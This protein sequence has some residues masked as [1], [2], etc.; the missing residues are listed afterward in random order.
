M[1]VI[2]NEIQRLFPVS[3]GDYRLELNK[4]IYDEEEAK[5]RAVDYSLQKK[6][7]LADQSLTIPV[8]GIFDLYKNNKKVQTSKVLLLNL[9]IKTPRE[10]FIYKGTEYQIMNQLRLKP[11]IYAR[12]KEN[13][14]PEVQF[15]LAKWGFRLF[16]AD[17]VLF[18]KF[19]KGPRIPV[20]TVAKVLGISDEELR[21][22][23]P[24]DELFEKNRI[25][26]Y[27]ALE[28]WYETYYDDRGIENAKSALKS[29]LT[30]GYR[31]DPQVLKT[32]LGIE[33]TVLTKE[34][35]LESIKKFYKL[36]AGEIFPDDRDALYFKDFFSSE[37]ILKEHFSDETVQNNILRKIRRALLSGKSIPELG[38]NYLL[39]REIDKIFDM[40][41]TASLKQTNPVAILDNINRATIFG[42]GGIKSEYAVTQWARSVNPSHF[43]II[44]PLRTP[45][46]AKV[47]I[48]LFTTLGTRRGNR[49][50]QK[51]VL[52]V[53]TGKTEYLE[54]YEFF[55]TPIALPDEIIIEKG[56]IRFVDPKNVSVLYQG[57]ITK[58]SADK[59]MYALPNNLMF[60]T[61]TTNLIPFLPSISPAR[62]ARSANV[63]TQALALK[64][65]EP[66]LV[67]SG[68]S[69][70]P[71]EKIIGESYS[72]RA[73]I[74][75]KVSKVTD[76]FINIVDDKGKTHRI[77]LAKYL[78]L[79]NRAFFTF[80]PKVKE[81]DRVNKGDLIADSNFTK[82]G[83]LSLGVNLYTAFIPYKGLNY[84]DGIV[85][86]ESAAK[87]LT[88]T[89]LFVLKFE[90]RADVIIDKL[91]FR[92]L[93]PHLLP[94]DKFE[95]LDDDGV[96]KEGLIVNEND[97][98]VAGLIKHVPTSTD[99]YIGKLSRKYIREWDPFPLVW[100]RAASGKVVEVVKTPDLIS[101]SILSEEPA[102]VGD[103]IT[104]RHYAKGII[105]AIIPDEEM[106]RDSQGRP[107]EV[108][109]NPVNIIGRVNPSQLYEAVASKIAE[110]T[111]RPFVAPSFGENVYDLLDK[112]LK[113]LNLSA[114][115]RIYDPATGKWIDNV[116]TGKQYFLKLEHQVE[117]KMTAR[118]IY[119]SYDW[120][121]SPAKGGEHPSQ[122]LDLL[123]VYSLLGHNANANL[124]DAAI[125]KAE[126]NPDFWMAIENN[127]LLPPPKAPF[128]F[129]KFK[130]LLQS[131]G[132]N[133]HKEGTKFRL[134]PLTNKEIE[135]LV[136]GREIEN[137][138]M[139]IAGTLKEEK[140]GLFDPEKLG[141]LK[142]EKWGYIKLPFPI[143]NPLVLN[144][145]AAVLNMKVEDLEDVMTFKRE[146]NGKT[147]VD[148]II[149]AWN[150]LDLNEIL[151]TNQEILN[152]STDLNALRNANR[153]V[154]FIEAL[155]KAK[156][157]IEDL[158]I[159]KFPVLPPKM[160]PLYLSPKNEIFTSD[161]NLLYRDLKLAVDSYVEG[162]NLG[163]SQRRLATRAAKIYENIK[164]LQGLMDP[165][166]GYYA[167]RRP[168]GILKYIAGD[169]PKEGF[170][171]SKLLGRQQNLVGRS[172][173]IP[174][175]TLHP[176]EVGIPE[177]MSWTIFQ[178]FIL[179]KL[180][181]FGYSPVEAMNHFI[182]RT[183]IAKR[184][185][186]LVIQERPV[187][188]NRAPS[189]HKYNIMAFKVKLVPGKAL[190]ISPLVTQG[191]GADFDGDTMAVHVPVTKEAVEEAY[192]MFPSKHFLHEAK[193]DLILL[194]PRMEALWGLYTA[195]REGEKTD[196][197]FASIREAYQAYLRNEIR[198]N[199]I[200]QINNQTTTL[201]RAMVNDLLPTKYKA[202]DLVITKKKLEEIL[203]KIHQEDPRLAVDL[204][205]KLD[206]LGR[207][208]AY[209]EGCS[210]KWED[211]KPLPHNLQE[212]SEKLRNKSEKAINERISEL[213]KELI[214]KVKRLKNNTFVQLFE[215]G[216]R[217][218]ETQLLQMLVSPLQVADVYDRPLPR[219]I[220]RGYTEGMNVED[221]LLS[222]YGARRGMIEKYVQTGKPG[223]VTKELV[224]A[225]ADY[226]VTMKD[227]DTKQGVV[228]DVTDAN[229]LNRLAAEDANKI[230]RR[231]QV[232]TADIVD[233]LLKKNITKIKVRSPLTCEAPTGVCAY[234]YGYTDKNKFPEIG[235]YVGIKAAQYLTEPMT[236][237]SLSS[238]HTGGVV[239]DMGATF[240]DLRNVLEMRNIMYNRATLSTV[241][242]K[243]EKITK[244][245]QGGYSIIVSGVPH[246]TSPWVEP[247][248]EVGAEV[249]VGDA[250]TT[251]YPH[252]KDIYSLKGLDEA[253]T[254]VVKLLD[255]F[256]LSNGMKLDKRMFE[257]ISK[258]L[259]DTVIITNPGDTSYKIGDYVLI[260]KIKAEN[261]ALPST[262][263]VAIEDAENRKL[264]KSI[265]GF[266]KGRK[267]TTEDI[268]KLR[269]KGIRMVEVFSRPAEYMPVLK[270]INQIP[271]LR[272]DWMARMAYRDIKNTLAEGVLRAWTSD[273]AGWNPIPR[274]VYGLEMKKV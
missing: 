170:Y 150:K 252:P 243:V 131:L 116:F 79:N 216:T 171:Q 165:T 135:E 109:I 106:P 70:M 173:I 49:K 47:G 52:N 228:M 180:R 105:T 244:R 111:K 55:N 35:F 8:Y 65:P 210:I 102:M 266:E 117:D 224:A 151:K 251:G 34:V 196:K 172:V 269:K 40:D 10:S 104:N 226:V 64:N 158:V 220:T 221:Y 53:K 83:V 223:E 178:P 233:Q 256:Y 74:S 274:Y 185:R 94:S 273:I 164:I 91:K 81:G 177:E 145:V 174:D 42:E 98:L 130:A 155:K 197:K 203:K 62:A 157:R 9:P 141:G 237:M 107:F 232:I 146:L 176:D 234:C 118:Y 29:A 240:D 128:V 21:K 154:R 156:I 231:N 209:Y 30:T 181:S 113:D 119:G 182:N 124:Y 264:A 247:K 76:E 153:I 28:S 248:V 271:L 139:V 188:L 136:D 250:L 33:A 187:L 85:I 15:N 122:A 87:K 253:R 257:L 6:I 184:A 147:G 38:I 125:W 254:E 227:C 263:E 200:I 236:Q 19:T 120:D 238:V 186:D 68:L 114:T 44:D 36:R 192:Q 249:K 159:D 121:L 193:K 175:Q 272:D 167:R 152:K 169:A 207:E 194:L 57:N 110:K 267:L 270:G 90:K 86:S 149:D 218:N 246:V 46:G 75:G 215:S 214:D 230:V 198:A 222:A 255:N 195:T 162:R 219:L 262:L 103:K 213:R 14:E 43:G 96:I 84:E 142:G 161:F 51:E 31:F 235:E 5:E 89:Q 60:F 201:G 143:I 11:G 59:V 4:I 101:I 18:I 32:L 258:I 265:D 168:Q 67:Q 50:L 39:Q 7:K 69:E 144:G 129:L 80:T 82:D 13:G 1:F 127:Q 205:H 93:F 71:F 191:F 138:R 204:A 123:T 268:A 199:S 179:S 202:D 137:A 217:G 260:N 160:R 88:S 112:Q 3:A 66:P 23:F 229:V 37:D 245:P 108:L 22:V 115:D 12:I 189:L 132:I 99:T 56:K 2:L 58:M 41:L 208:F 95:K 241:N 163:M 73:P 17:D 148:A 134:L 100:D 92:S 211:L 27:R 78:P 140:G 261:A 45:E 259:F 63:L 225:A 77:T 25:E 206:V 54:A 72:I 20:Y 24:S 212:E 26:D 166:T 48:A 97:I 242:G 190:H 61:V 16:E 183:D 133:I 126:Y 239:K